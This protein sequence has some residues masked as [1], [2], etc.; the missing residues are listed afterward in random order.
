LA[1]TKNNTKHPKN[2]TKTTKNPNT[3]PQDGKMPQKQMRPERSTK[4][5]PDAK[6]SDRKTREELKPQRKRRKQAGIKK[7][8]KPQ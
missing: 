1:K 6:F 4:Y 8:E 5:H 7:T 2:N 3:E